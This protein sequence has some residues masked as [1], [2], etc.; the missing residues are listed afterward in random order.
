MDQLVCIA[1]KEFTF[2]E[3]TNILTEYSHKYRI[4]QMAAIAKASGLLMQ[5]HW[6]DDR[7]Y[8]AVTYFTCC[9]EA[10]MS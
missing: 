4:E 7:Q 10:V 1:G 5:Q 8:F 6:I 3:G 2:P 9:D